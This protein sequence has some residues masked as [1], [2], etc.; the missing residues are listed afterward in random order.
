MN[1]IFKINDYNTITLKSSILTF[2]IDKKTR[3]VT[4]L[5]KMGEETNRDCTNEILNQLSK[6]ISWDITIDSDYNLSQ[7]I[8]NIIN[9]AVNFNCLNILMCFDKIIME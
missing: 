6:Y 5:E 3:T 9:G 1:N 4:E 8:A 2:K 7:V